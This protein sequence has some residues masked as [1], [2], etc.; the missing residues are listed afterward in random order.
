MPR[1]RIKKKL[2]SRFKLGQQVALDTRAGEVIGTVLE[3]D[4]NTAVIA[5][6]LDPTIRYRIPHGV[7]ST[8]KIRFL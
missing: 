5:S 2:P 6:D 3:C 7:I 4:D 8:G 1:K